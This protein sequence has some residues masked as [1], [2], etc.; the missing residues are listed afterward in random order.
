MSFTHPFILFLLVAPLAWLVWLWR[1]S[2]HRAG[3]LLKGLALAA[4]VIALSEPTTT[5]PRTRVGAVVLVDTSASITRGDLDRAASLIVEMQRHRH[6]NWI[7]VVPFAGQPRPL[8]RRETTGDLRLLNTANESGNSTNIEAAL[9]GSMSAIPS[10][11]IPRLVLLSDGNENEGSTARAIAELQR[12]HVPVDTIPLA[13]RQNNGFRLE[14]VSMPHQA[15]AGEQI[16]IDLTIDSP[17]DVQATVTISAE[18]KDLGSNPVDLKSGA[19]LVR[20][21]ARVNSSGATSISGTIAAPQLGD[22]P[23]EQAIELRRAKI[24]YLSQDPPG[25]EANLLQAFAEAD[26]DITRETALIDKDLSGIQL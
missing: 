23:F 18:G 11:Y 25:T 2:I 19:N 14:S 7:K 4:I 24:M 20:I 22:I 21:H 13:G 16:P 12:L 26:F 9:T 15:Y 3:L 1:T 5:V 10:G 6:G 8:S 17:Q